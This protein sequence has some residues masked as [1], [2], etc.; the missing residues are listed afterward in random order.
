M[1]TRV[2]GVGGA[3]PIPRS[4]S[5]VAELARRR[6]IGG[7]S[8]FPDAEGRCEGACDRT[9]PRVVENPQG[10]RYNAEGPEARSASGASQISHFRAPPEALI[11]PQFGTPE[12]PPGAPPPGGGGGR[13]RGGRRG[14]EWGIIKAEGGRGPDIQTWPP[15]RGPYTPQGGLGGVLWGGVRALCAVRSSSPFAKLL[16]AH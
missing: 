1:P 13:P 8:G 9:G 3:P 14:P 16:I 6:G 7:P 2:G 12:P 5:S 10:P 15:Q 11:I 4:Q